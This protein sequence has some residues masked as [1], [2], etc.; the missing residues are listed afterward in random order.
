MEK[1]QEGGLNYSTS[2]DLPFGVSWNT[3]KN[4]TDGKSSALW[5]SENIKSIQI[6]RTIEIPFTH[7]NGALVYPSNMR[8]FGHGLARTLKAYVEEAADMVQQ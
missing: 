1:Y 3:A 5:V 4:Y 7:A 8:E 2:D 6:S